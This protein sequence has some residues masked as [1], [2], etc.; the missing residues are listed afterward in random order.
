MVVVSISF[1]VFY[2]FS[3]GLIIGL[4]NL[5]QRSKER[6]YCGQLDK[7]NAQEI[8]VLIPFRNEAHRIQG[9]LNSI[10][11]LEVF[12]SKFVFIDDHSTD[13]TSDIINEHLA[14]INFELLY[15]PQSYYGKKRALRF[16][17]EQTKSNFI[18]TID[19][20]VELASDYFAQIEK[21]GQADMYVLPAI[22]ISKKWYEHLYEIDLL[23]VTAANSGLAGLKRPIMASGANL[24][25]RRSTF[26]K[27]DDLPSHIHAASGDDTYLL[28]DFRNHGADVR[29]LTDP[30]CSIQTETPQSF[31]EFID[32]RLR[33]VGKTGDLKDH[34][35]TV[36]AVLQAVLTVFFFGL[37]VYFSINFA[38]KELLLI[39]SLKTMVDL[40][41]FF[42]YFN[43]L[44]RVTSWLLIPLYELLFP[45]YT[46]LIAVLLF[47]YKPKWKGRAIYEKRH[48]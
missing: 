46:M 28:R 32:Q 44:G 43:R 45:F 12:P 25:Y 8:V 19:A 11:K 9:L 7:L 42:P 27:A 18:L 26:E 23:L 21:L 4:G 15:S 24:L 6:T 39:F 16:G 13:N 1:I 20:D 17:T 40:V 37:L 34:L 14:G 29:L 30:A 41:L 31:K 48:P 5:K 47:T 33:W 3:I 10:K 38:L 35:S 22:M 2:T 36:L